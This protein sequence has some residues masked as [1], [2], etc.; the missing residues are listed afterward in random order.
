M[1]KREGP[2]LQASTLPVIFGSYF[3]PPAFVLSFQALFPS[4]FFFSNRR[5]GK[6]TQRKKKPFAFGMKHS[7]CFLLSTF[8]QRWALH[9]PQALCL[10]FF[11]ALCYSSSGAFLSFGDGMNRKWGEGG[12]RG[13]SKEEGKLLGQR[14]GLKNP[15]AG[16]EDVFLIHPQNG[17]N[18]LILNWCIA[19]YWFTPANDK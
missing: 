7:P 3:Y 2:C 18:G 16:E 8:L 15:W 14:K 9:L 11:E 4:I 10:C 5:K 12:R 13:G 6:K 19:G 1:Q 17:L